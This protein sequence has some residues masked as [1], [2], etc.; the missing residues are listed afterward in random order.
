MRGLLTFTVIFLSLWTAPISNALE[1]VQSVQNCAGEV[2][3]VQGTVLIRQDDQDKSKNEKSIQ[4]QAGNNVFAGDLINTGSNGSVKILLKDKT[5]V[6]L[7]PS[8]LFKVTQF[9][10]KKGADREV[11]LDMMF[12]K[13]RIGVSKK[14]T[15]TGKFNIKTK[16]ATMGVRG[17]EFV[18]SSA[19]DVSD[20]K[21]KSTPPKTEVTVLQGKVDVAQIGAAQ[22]APSH[23]TAGTQLVTN[24]GGPPGAMVKL[25]E[26][27]LTS[28]SSSSKVADNTF[29]KA[30]TIAPSTEQRSTSTSSS[31]TASSSS[32]SSSSRAPAEANGSTSSSGANSASSASANTS[33]TANN[34]SGASASLISAPPLAGSIQSSLATVAAAVPTVN[35]S[36]SEIGV[37]GAPSV[38]NIASPI[39]QANRSYHVT[40]VV[41][42]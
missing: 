23:L 25:N 24:S 17:T 39:T 31:S 33:A 28:V 21:E 29:T 18:V 10:P 14:I 35:V 2:V 26:T 9:K 38:V 40:V 41:S 3:S 6:D 22:A 37:P 5:I 34:S 1:R 36:F 32:G 19:L 15:G 11:D 42:Q 20:S 30:V 12:G 8:S 4:L 27:Q 16:A 13:V 7:G